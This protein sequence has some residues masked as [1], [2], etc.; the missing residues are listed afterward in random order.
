MKYTFVMNVSNTEQV[1]S[2][3]DSQL[4]DMV[5]NRAEKRREKERQEAER[6][7]RENQERR[8]EE[9]RKK[10][11]ERRKK[12][13]RGIGAVALTAAVLFGAKSL[14]APSDAEAD[15]NVVGDNPLRAEEVMNPITYAPEEVVGD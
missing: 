3:E 11:A 12:I 13:I 2:N 15:E 1:L 8:E 4:F 9:Q 5:N 6:T 10:E 7:Q 14:F